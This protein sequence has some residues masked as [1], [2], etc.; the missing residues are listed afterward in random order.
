VIAE[1]M[2]WV[3]CTRQFWEN[4]TK[5]VELKTFKPYCENG[6]G[7]LFNGKFVITLNTLGM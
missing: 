4:K 7:Y 1:T 6:S 5:N 2:H 3:V